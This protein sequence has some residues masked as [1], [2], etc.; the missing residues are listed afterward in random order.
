MSTLNDD[1]CI[2]RLSGDILAAGPC[3]MRVVDNAAWLNVTPLASFDDTGTK[4]MHAGSVGVAMDVNGPWPC[5]SVFINSSVRMTTRSK[6]LLRTGAASSEEMATLELRRSNIGWIMPSSKE[7]TGTNAAPD[8]G[9][10]VGW[11]RRRLRQLTLGQQP[12]LQAQACT[13]PSQPARQSEA[14]H[15]HRPN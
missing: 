12:W 2:T 6:R 7:S 13:C 15:R 10:L 14:Q 1:S 3:P 9:V 5:G 8:L 4:M 11:E